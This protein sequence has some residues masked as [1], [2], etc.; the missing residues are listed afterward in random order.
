[1]SSAA[2]SKKIQKV[3]R[4]QCASKNGITMKIYEKMQ[5]WNN[6]KKDVMDEKIVH[7]CCCNKKV[8]LKTN[9]PHIIHEIV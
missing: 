7:C 5:E 4:E 6:T 9:S 2:N 3:A 8:T 1:M